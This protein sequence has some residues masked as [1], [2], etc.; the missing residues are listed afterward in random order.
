VRGGEACKQ[1]GRDVQRIHER[2]ERH[3][4]C[5]QSFVLAVGGGA[6]LDAV[7]FAA[8]TAHR[9]VRLVRMPSTVLAQNDAGIGVKNAVNA[10]GRKNFVGAFAPPFAVV[11]DA[12]LLDTLDP[13]DRRA[14]IAEAVKVAL[15]KDAA[16]FEALFAERQRLA[17]FETEAMERMIV[18]CAELHLEHIRTSGDPFELGSARPLDFGHWSAHRLEE[19]VEGDLRHGEAVAVGIALDVL[20]SH[21]VGRLDE[22]A[23]HRILVLL[24]DLG[25]DL[26]RPALRWL[27][28]E[29]ALESFREHLGGPLCIT[30][31]DG[32]GRGVEVRGIDVGTMRT[33]I[34][35]LL[36]RR[37]GEEERGHAGPLSDVRQGRP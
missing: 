13:R 18:R 10:F 6:V 3:R 8:S 31:L 27:D 25:F 5:R 15:I 4:I 22:I 26:A 36:R 35:A 32:V 11:N 29:A 7:G 12:A 21:A 30:L 1:D 14:G 34:D 9:G 28:V 23:A 37:A 33:C 17:R 20:Y 24:E 19:I 16:F 2:I